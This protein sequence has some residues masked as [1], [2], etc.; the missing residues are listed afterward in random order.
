MNKQI[1]R[2][3]FEAHVEDLKDSARCA[4]HHQY[5]SLSPVDIES[6]WEAYEKAEQD[7]I[8]FFDRLMH[9]VDYHI[10]QARDEG[11]KEGQR[12]KEVP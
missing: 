4:Y 7:L 11:R 3:G 9:D 6:S 1:I 2:K 10:Q 8:S 5:T 12:F